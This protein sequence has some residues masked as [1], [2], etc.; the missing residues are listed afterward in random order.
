MSVKRSVM[1]AVSLLLFVVAVPL[2]Q[3]QT[4]Q[5]NRPARRAKA[6]A[7][8]VGKARVANVPSV[9]PNRPMTKKRVGRTK[10]DN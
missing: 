3:A 1:I 8:L 6:S 7:V 10:V 4:V 9:R 2:T 5:K